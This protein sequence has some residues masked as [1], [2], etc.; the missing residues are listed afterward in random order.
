MTSKVGKE[1]WRSQCVEN[2]E[3][4]RSKFVFRHYNNL[5]RQLHGRA[6][7]LVGIGNFVM[8]KNKCLTAPQTTAVNISCAIYLFFNSLVAKQVGPKHEHLRDGITPLDFIAQRPK[9]APRLLWRSSGDEDVLPDD[10]PEPLLEA[11]E[12]LAEELVP[13]HLGNHFLHLLSSVSLLPQRNNVLSRAK[14]K[15]QN[16]LQCLG[17]NAF[18]GS[19]KSVFTSLNLFQWREVRNEHFLGVSHPE[20]TVVPHCLPATPDPGWQTTAWPV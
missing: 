8:W 3:L 6:N 7:P 16:A 1:C 11:D 9:R 19:E 13:Q 4:E 17:G 5:R 18:C 20:V 10:E 2:K 15:E 12:D 14:G